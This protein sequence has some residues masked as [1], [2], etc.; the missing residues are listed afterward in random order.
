MFQF[1]RKQKSDFYL[2]KDQQDFLFPQIHSEGVLDLIHGSLVRPRPPG[3]LNIWRVVGA[4]WT[5]KQGVDGSN[6]KSGQE[7]NLGHFAFIL[8]LQG[9]GT[10]H[11]LADLAE[12]TL[13]TARK[14]IQDDLQDGS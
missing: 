8:I 1:T 14:S 10:V 2:Y 6:L 13:K 5:T 11:Y 12:A 4:I 9:L 3:L 7:P